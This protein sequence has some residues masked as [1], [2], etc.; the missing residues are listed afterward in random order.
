MPQKVRGSS[1]SCSFTACPT[2]VP[3]VLTLQL[4]DACS[5]AEE[6]QGQVA[7]ARQEVTA[8]LA[9]RERRCQEL[10]AEVC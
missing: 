10:R 7:A 3:A 4:A 8:V 6:Q 9:G 5:S 1:V 2:R